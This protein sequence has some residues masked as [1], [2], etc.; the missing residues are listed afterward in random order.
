[1]ADSRRIASIVCLTVAP[2]HI[3]KTIRTIGRLFAHSLHIVDTLGKANP[4]PVIFDVGIQAD[5]ATVDVK[6][7]KV[8]H[9]TATIRVLRLTDDVIAATVFN[10][11]TILPTENIKELL[12]YG[13]HILGAK[14][15]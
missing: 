10:T 2:V 1:M 7:S 5:T 15:E 13:I 11:A 9:D 14:K 4:S 3:T 12:N 8:V 6:V